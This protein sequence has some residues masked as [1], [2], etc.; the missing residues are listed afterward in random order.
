MAK[1]LRGAQPPRQLVPPN[2]KEARLGKEGPTGR[3]T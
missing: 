3:T 1:K 2:L